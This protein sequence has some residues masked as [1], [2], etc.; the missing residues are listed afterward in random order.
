MNFLKKINKILKINEHLICRVCKTVSP[1]ST[2]ICPRCGA[3][4]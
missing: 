4:L 1:V 3:K 2:I